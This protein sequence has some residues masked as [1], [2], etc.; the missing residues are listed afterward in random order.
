MSDC[1]A[2]RNCLSHNKLTNGTCLFLADQKRAKIHI[3]PVRQSIDD[4]DVSQECEVLLF[5]SA[6]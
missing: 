2:K 5:D 4:I 6:L 1:S 3:R